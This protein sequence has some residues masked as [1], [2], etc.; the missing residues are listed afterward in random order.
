V[1]LYH[2]VTPAEHDDF[3]ATVPVEAIPLAAV[4]QVM[5]A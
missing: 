4:N 1:L 3:A 5:T 2:A